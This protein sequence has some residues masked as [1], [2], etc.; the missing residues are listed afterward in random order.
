MPTV[1][2]FTASTKNTSRASVRPIRPNIYEAVLTVNG[3][4][5]IRTPLPQNFSFSLSSEYG[6]PF[7]QPLS[8]IFL[9]QA[10]NVIEKGMSF[11]IGATTQ[12]KWQSAA[13]WSGGSELAIEVPFVLQAYDAND[14][15][16]II[17]KMRD[18]LALAAPSENDAGMLSSPGPVPKI[19]GES[20]VLEGNHIM[21]EIG[22]FFKMEPC[23][24]T[25]ITE[26][27]DTQFESTGKPIGA[28]V[29]IQLR[30]YWTCTK[31][32]LQRYFLTGAGN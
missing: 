16:E 13:I 7:N 24:I 2:T 25:S 10:G 30:S 21:I 27:F 32:D 26:D 9:G 14:A 17:R 22:T 15:G 18:L 6:N 29:R 23:I 5:Y 1:Q 8:E 3:V 4:P 28:V 19:F 11:G 31:Q 12:N 20:S